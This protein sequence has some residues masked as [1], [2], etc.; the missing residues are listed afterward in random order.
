M[1]NFLTELDATLVSDD[2]IW[3]LGSDLVYQSDIL[4][5]TITVPKGFKTDFASVP[6][7]IPVASNALIDRAHRESVIHD[8]LY[9]IDSI[10]VV[11][12][13][14]ANSVFLEAMTLRQKP[15]L[16]RWCMYLGVCLGGFAAFHKVTVLKHNN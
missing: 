10:P 11:T 15:F 2:V 6:R 8:Y 7:W 4:N 9:C 1:S 12:E 5:T 16:I 13:S 3:E 14:Q